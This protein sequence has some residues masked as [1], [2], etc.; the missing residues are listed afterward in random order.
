MII[1][2]PLTL[3]ITPF[4]L[5]ET[6]HIEI[7]THFIKEKMNE[8]IIC[9]P[10]VMSAEQLANVLTKGISNRVF[11]LIVNTLG[12]IDIFSPT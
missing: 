11:D 1:R 2:Q 10:F 6:K 3:L 4:N 9:M 12:A 5:I 7:D 8:G